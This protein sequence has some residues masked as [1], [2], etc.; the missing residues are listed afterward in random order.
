MPEAMIKQ[1]FGPESVWPTLTKKELFDM[2]NISIRAGST[3]RP[4]KMRE[5]DQW[6]QLMPIIQETMEK[7]MLA[8]AQGQA[9]VAEPMTAL[10]DET[11]RR[12]D[13]KLSAKEILGLNVQPQMMPQ[14]VQ[15][16][17]PVHAPQ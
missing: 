5:R 10:L 3:S 7:V 6:L 12:F 8:Q 16:Q 15:P 4:N 1:H 11:L 9:Q 13:E 14:P 2:V 17:I